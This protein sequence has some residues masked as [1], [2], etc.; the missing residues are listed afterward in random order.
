MEMLYS[1][2]DF[3]ISTVANIDNR[4]KRHVGG[5]K[6]TPKNT[7]TNP[8]RYVELVPTVKAVLKSPINKINNHSEMSLIQITTE[9]IYKVK[10]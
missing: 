8:F 2:G 7:I 9:S 6:F 4:P 5:V 1:N 3:Q 10:L